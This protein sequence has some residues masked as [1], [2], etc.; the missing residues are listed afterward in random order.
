MDFY[1]KTFDILTT[2]E[3]YEILK[4]RLEVFLF[5]QNIRYLDTD[6]IDYDSLHVF[7][8]E[9][10][11]VVSYLRAFR[12]EDAVKIGRV[13]TLCH[14]KGDGRRLMEFAEGKIKEH[15]GCDRIVLHS[16][17]QAQGFYEKLGYKTVSDEYI[18]AGIPHITMEK[19]L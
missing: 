9:N 1:A 17:K 19:T 8:K 13:L 14:G 4:S 16:Q 6:D 2:G 12:Y 11:R 5:E 15:F 3:I 7:C 18:E 10:G